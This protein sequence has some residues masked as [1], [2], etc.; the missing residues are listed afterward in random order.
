VAASQEYVNIFSICRCAHLDVETCHVCGSGGVEGALHVSHALG[1]AGFPMGQ[2][3]YLS[4]RVLFARAPVLG[5]C[6]FVSVNIYSICRCAHL[7]VE[8]CHV[9]GSGGVEGA[10]HVSHALG[11]AG[12]PMGQPSY[13]CSRVLFARAPVLGLCFFVSV[14]IYSMCSCAH[15]DVETCHVGR[16]GGVEGALHVSH[17]LGLAG[18][19]MG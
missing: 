7:D 6:F 10:L 14:N 8:T 1:L 3:S 17:A 4:S 9:C 13:L 19:P 15:L 5:L 12:F 18:F 11:L 2:P 16:S